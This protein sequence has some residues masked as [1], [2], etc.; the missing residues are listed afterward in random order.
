MDAGRPGHEPRRSRPHMPGYGVP[1]TRK[2]MLEWS[3]VSE[4]IAAARTYW[5][6]STG[7]GGQPHAVPV[8]GIWV[9]DTLFF[10]GAPHAR[11]VRNLAAN[12]LAVAHLESGEQVVILEGTVTRLPSLGAE[13]LPLVAAQ[14]EAKYGGTFEDR[15]S[16]ALSPRV[17][18]AWS[19][20]LSD[21]TRWTFA[22]G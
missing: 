1:K 21:A 17:A 5:I 22:A 15:G 14:S 18:Y 16:L 2:G 9:A 20:F 7:P 13:V 10:D 8:W 11:W 6:G 19:N 12:P 4:R 3:D